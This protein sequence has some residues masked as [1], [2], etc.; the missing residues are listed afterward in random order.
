[1]HP[2]ILVESHGEQSRS[3]SSEATALIWMAM[4]LAPGT[5]WIRMQDGRS[6]MCT[7]SAMA[8]GDSRTTSSL[9]RFLG[10][11]EEVITSSWRTT[12]R[13]QATTGSSTTTFLSWSTST[14][15]TTS[16]TTLAGPIASQLTIATT[17]SET[18]TDSTLTQAKPLM[19]SL[20]TLW[21]RSPL[22]SVAGLKQPLEL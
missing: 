17:G 10:S 9:S 7:L 21:A 12:L 20:A 14:M 1:M 5:G 15:A 16:E 2:S 6:I 13:T 3:A 4:R 8:T 18:W 11:L 22:T 19:I